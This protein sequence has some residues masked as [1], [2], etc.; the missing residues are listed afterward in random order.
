MLAL[1]IVRDEGGLQL[2]QN[3]TTTQLD[4]QASA[5]TKLQEE[6]RMVRAAY[7]EVM[8]LSKEAVRYDSEYAG[9]GVLMSICLM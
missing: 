6:L 9:K 7:D 2:Q 8:D 4:A 3:L 1:S 5:L